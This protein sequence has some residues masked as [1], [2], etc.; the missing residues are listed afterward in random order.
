MLDAFPNLV[1]YWNPHFLE[2]RDNGSPII[3]CAA[4]AMGFVHDRDLGGVPCVLVNRN[5]PFAAWDI[6]HAVREESMPQ[7][8]SQL[9]GA[10]VI[11]HVELK[12][13]LPLV[14]HGLCEVCHAEVGRNGSWRPPSFIRHTSLSLK[15]A[16]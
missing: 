7:S 8:F 6:R 1:R 2:Y 13:Y 3:V 9:D 16:N 12:A 14:R 10:V 5:R 4:L 11:G 15:I